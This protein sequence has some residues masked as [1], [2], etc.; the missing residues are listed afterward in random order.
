MKQKKYLVCIDSDGCAI[1]SMNR[2]HIHCFGP[3]FISV[4]HLEDHREQILARWNEMNLFSSTRGINRFKG[5]AMILPEAGTEDSGA[6]IREFV[7]WTSQAPELSNDALL[8][9]C[10]GSASQNPVFAK[11][12]EWSLTVN[13]LI[14]QLPVSSPFPS[15]RP[16]LEEISRLADIAVVSSANKEA[17]LEEWRQGSLDCFV[18]RFYSQSEGSKSQCIGDMVRLGY[19]PDHILMV[20]DAPGDYVAAAENHVWF[21]PILAGKEDDSW[22]SLKDSFIRQFFQDSFQKQLQQGLVHMMWENLGG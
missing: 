19:T 18:S 5:L 2:K 22:K 10:S 12:L 7:D 20:G 6:Q 9:K 8:A 17:I 14:E 16:C 13:T 15:V 1:D 11:A 3:A 4:W 21:Y